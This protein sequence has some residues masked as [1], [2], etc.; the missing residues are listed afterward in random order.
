M[1]THFNHQSDYNEMKEAL[2]AIKEHLDDF[3]K[4]GKMCPFHKED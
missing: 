2:T 3:L 4:D 1:W